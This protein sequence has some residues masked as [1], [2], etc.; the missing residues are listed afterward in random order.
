MEN[1]KIGD[2]LYCVAPDSKKI[3]FIVTECVILS[4]FVGAKE[5]KYSYS[6]TM[7]IP[8]YSEL[9]TKEY[10]FKTQKEAEKYAHKMALEAERL[11]LEAKANRDANKQSEK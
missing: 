10:F 7:N 3:D 6:G 8:H 5:T 1:I 2:R 11:R 4:V 9:L